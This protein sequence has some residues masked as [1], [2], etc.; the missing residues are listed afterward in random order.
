[1][2]KL[3]VSGVLLGLFI[4]AGCGSAPQDAGQTS[5]QTRPQTSTQPSVEP[6]QGAAQAPAVIG[7]DMS[8]IKGKDWKLY[9]IRTSAGNGFSREKLDQKLKEF[10]VEADWFTLRFGDETVS[11]V[12]APNRYNAPFE[13]GDGYKIFF[14][15]PASTLMASFIEPEDITEHEFFGFI[16]RINRWNVTADGKLEIFTAD[17]EGSEVVLVFSAE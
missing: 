11:G 4:F 13:Q 16:S 15:W 5:Q 8:G 2:K 10:G 9:A 17:D 1:M 12:G 3:L 6:P 7:A 14:G